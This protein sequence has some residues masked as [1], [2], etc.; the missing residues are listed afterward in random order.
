MNLE[1]IDDKN[2][3]MDQLELYFKIFFDIS[4]YIFW[5]T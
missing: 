5:Y 2:W 4:Q 1:G 3:D